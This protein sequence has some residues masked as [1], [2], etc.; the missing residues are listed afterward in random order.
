MLKFLKSLVY[1]LDGLIFNYLVKKGF[2][3]FWDYY[4][5][6]D[7]GWESGYGDRDYNPEEGYD[8]PIYDYELP[9]FPVPTRS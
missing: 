5:G 1:K 6:S 9:D 2:I 3:L 8:V 4:D 7:Y